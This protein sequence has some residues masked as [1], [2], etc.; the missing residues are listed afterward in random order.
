MKRS[1]FIINHSDG[2]IGRLD[3]LLTFLR[4]QGYSVEL[5]THPLDDYRYLNTT[6]KGTKK[7]ICIRRKPH[8]IFNL[9]EDFLLSL[10]FIR[11][12]NFDIFIGTNNFDTL[13]AV[14]SRFFF[15]RRKRKII[16]YPS[17]YSEDRFSSKFLNSTY[18]FVENV[19]V[20]HSDLIISNSNTAESRRI[21]RHGLSRSKSLVMANPVSLNN[22]EFPQKKIKKDQFIYIGVVNKE[23]GLSCMLR[24]IYPLV[25]K[26]VIIGTGND[27]EESLNVLND[28]NIETT[29]YGQKDHKFVLKCLRKFHGFGL[30]PYNTSE[31]W[32][33]YCSP[34]K[35]GEYIAS[36]LPVLMSDVPE[37]SQVVKNMKLGIVYHSLNI[38]IIERKLLDFDSKDYH[39]RSEKYYAVN[40]PSYL[41]EKMILRLN[42][43]L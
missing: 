31:K 39:L 30:A 20:K 26:I 24:E 28:H 8:G 25:K 34:V 29:S 5:L 16:F 40:S 6:F 11:S 42:A 3:T 27:L 23:H 41:F 1:F 37:V 15:R 7:S 18:N 21:E 13:P 36:G 2:K 22:L 38:S 33:I 14:L 9:I 43:G 19:V 10:K 4:T 35:V 32:T 17:D 12:A